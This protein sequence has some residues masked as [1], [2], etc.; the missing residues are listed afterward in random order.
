MTNETQFPTLG[1]PGRRRPTSRRR[2]R[3]AGSRSSPSSAA[4]GWA[5]STRRSSRTRSAASRSRSSAPAATARRAAAA[6]LPAR[7]RDAGAAVHPNI[8]ALYEAGRTRRTA[9]TSSRWSSSPASR[10]TTTCATHMGG[11]HPTHAQL[12]DRLRLFDD[13]L[14]RRQ[15][16]APARR[17]PP[18]PEAVEHPRRRRR[19]APSTGIVASRSASQ[20]PPVPPPGQDP[21]LRPRAHHRTPTSRRRQPLTE[22][23]DIRGTLAYMSPE[24]ARGDTARSTCAAT[25]TRSA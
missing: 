9:S 6:P 8:A 19:P 3:S 13:D 11:E 7:G 12:R 15:L 18:R 16:R 25:S 20:R 22:L 5:S 4:A 10:S 1:V 23:G 24:Q 14:P 21:R 2:T 17:H